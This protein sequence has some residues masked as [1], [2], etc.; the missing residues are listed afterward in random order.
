VPGARGFVLL[1]PLEDY[2]PPRSPATGL[3][4]EFRTGRAQY[5]DRRDLPHLERERFERIRDAG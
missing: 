2:D 3:R 1:R 5:V 4:Y